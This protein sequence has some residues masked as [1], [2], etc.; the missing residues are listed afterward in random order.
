MFPLA[1]FLLNSNPTSAS[2]KKLDIF[3]NSRSKFNFKVKYDFLTN[4]ARNKC[5]T[6]ILCDFDSAIHLK[7]KKKLFKVIFKVKKS[8]SRSSKRKYH[9][10]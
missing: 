5:N 8:I 4:E 2:L 7:K 9:F 3:L 1:F 10:Y 6:S